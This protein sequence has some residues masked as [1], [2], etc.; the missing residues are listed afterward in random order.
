[1]AYN[2]ASL[3]WKGCFLHV[4][5]NDA[6]RIQ[7]IFQLHSGAKCLQNI[8]ER[9]HIEHTTSILDFGLE[10]TFLSVYYYSK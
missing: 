10:I 5:P 6:V 3:G 2:M 4:M 1:M 8:F 9:S 7:N